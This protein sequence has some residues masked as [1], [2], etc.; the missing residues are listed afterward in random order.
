[1]SPEM[2]PEQKSGYSK[3]RLNGKKIDKVL[4]EMGKIGLEIHQS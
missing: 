1:M 3:L 4:D 2:T